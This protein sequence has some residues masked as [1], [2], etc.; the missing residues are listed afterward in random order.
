VVKSP[1]R[2]IF[3]ICSVSTCFVWFVLVY[4]SIRQLESSKPPTGLSSATDQELAVRPWRDRVVQLEATITELQHALKERDDHIALQQAM[5]Q[6]QDRIPPGAALPA[7][8]FPSATTMVPGDARFAGNLLK[9]SS[10]ASARDSGLTALGGGMQGP[11]LAATTWKTELPRDKDLC[12]FQDNLDYPALGKEEVFENLSPQECCELCGRHNRDGNVCAVAVISTRNDNPP[13]ACWLKDRVARGVHKPGVKACWPPGHPP[14]PHAPPPDV[15]VPPAVPGLTGQSMPAQSQQSMPEPPPHRVDRVKTLSALTQSWQPSTLIMRADA[16]RGAVKHVW[17]NY[18]SHAWGYDELKP[19]SGTGKDGHFRH[20]ITMVDSLDTLWILG[21]KDEFNNAK[22]WLQAN[23]E[24]KVSAIPGSA[25]LFE[26]H[27]RSFGGLLSA[28]D[29][30]KDKMFLDLA[31]P[32]ANRIVGKINGATG[33]AP[34]TFGGGRGGMGCNS[35]AE[36][37]TLQLEMRYLSH[38]TGDK[39]YAEKTDRFYETIRNR[40]SLDGLYPNCFMN[41]KGKITFGADG[42]SFYEYLVKVWL[43]GGRKDEKLF[44][45]YE[46]AVGGL[47]KY[48]ISV[49][50]KDA[51]E[52]ELTFLNDFFWNGKGSGAGN[53]GRID[54]S[55]EHLTCFIPGWLALGLE[56]LKDK[57]RRKKLAEDIGYTCWQ[58]Y[59]RQP[60][61]IG[62]ERVKKRK[63][64]LSLTDTKEYILRPEAAEGWWY[65]HELIPDPKYREWGWET[66]VA[67]E[68]WLW[69]EH[70]YA[71]L[72]DVSKTNSIR[73]DRM[74]SFFLAETLKYLF[75]L[76]DPDHDIHLDR[77]VFNTEAHPLSI[78]SH[79]PMAK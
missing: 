55:M 66:F 53:T 17:E 68:K 47:E 32:L 23:F 79:T 62:P 19:I 37:G 36:S 45:M 20:A 34:Y 42:D 14:I 50:N 7:L 73:L 10:A 29:L 41:G 60:T 11:F 65:L 69:V 72:K 78:L 3:W 16:I 40:D 64:D 26:T 13:Q 25:S 1:N 22:V 61:G 2:Y 5:T 77:Y 57:E 48:L 35:L 54:Y 4:C 44:K 52:D 71:S 58:M 15:R 28:Y 30:S 75:L 12:L 38:V 70:G 51:G 39:N 6:H 24:K 43:Q 33:I 18:M 49:G 8:G 27:I 56:Y 74:E 59:K 31:M 67:F 21:L 76:Q 46:D 63:M 9:R